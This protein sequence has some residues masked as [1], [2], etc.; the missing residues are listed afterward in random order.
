MPKLNIQIWWYCSF[1]L[2]WTGNTFLGDRFGQ[3]NQSVWHLPNEM[4]IE[5]KLTEKCQILKNV[6]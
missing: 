3:K 6:K 5:K 4:D 1:V 2:F